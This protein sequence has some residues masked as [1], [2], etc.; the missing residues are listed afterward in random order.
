[1]IK[2]CYETGQ[3]PSDFTKCIINHI[4]NEEVYRR[5]GETRS[6]LKTLKTRRVKLIGHI[7]RQNSLLSRIIEG[8]IEG[9]NSRGRPPLDYISQIVRYMDCRSYCELKRK[10]EKRQEWRI[11]A[12]QPLGC[13]Q[14]KKNNLCEVIKFSR[15][16]TQ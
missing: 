4:T 6:F 2:E 3:V 11:A 1:M 8:A 10:A 9:N 7:L 5:V 15:I 16:L 14:K 12:N 13:K